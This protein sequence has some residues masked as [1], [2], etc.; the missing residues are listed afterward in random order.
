MN[1]AA[2]EIEFEDRS[3]FRKWLAKNHASSE[4]IWLVLRKGS[5]ALS[6][7]DALEEAICFGWIDG[8]M[9]S[10][11]SELY[12]KYFSR[13][14]DKENWSEKNRKIHQALKEKGLMTKAGMDA[15]TE[16]TDG[17]SAGSKQDIHLAHIRT[18]KA[19]LGNEPEALQ[20]YEQK[21]P[22]RQKQ[23]A[24]FYCDAKGEE[25]RKKRLAKII[26]AMKT[27]YDGMLY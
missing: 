21:P 10:I 2:A 25:T 15:Y 23:F 22:S 27:G 14:K 9:K 3:A 4:G 19:A 1:D 12:K 8:V 6:A 11:D 7:T 5:K 26:E 24:G 20:L 18:L 13:R 17:A 16:K